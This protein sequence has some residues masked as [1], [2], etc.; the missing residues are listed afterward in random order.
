MVTRELSQLTGTV[1]GYRRLLALA[2]DLVAANEMAVEAADPELESEVTEGLAELV[3]EIARLEVQTLFS[4]ELDDRPAILSVN[5]GA[6]GTDAQDW[7]EMLLRMYLRWAEQ[8][9]FQAAVTEALAGEEAGVKSATIEVR[10]PHAYGW[11]GSEHGVH[12]LVRLSPFDSAHR[13]HT[14]FASVD[15]VP[16]LEEE[17]IEIEIPDEELRI[18]T[19]RAGGP[20]GQYVN[21][22]DSAVRITHLP[23]GLVTT[24]QSERSQLSNKIVAMKH[25]K[26]KL[27]ERRRQERE[28]EMAQLRGEQ[29]KIDF[30]S[31]IRSYVLHPYQMVKDHRTGA[32]TSSV[33]RVLDGD[34]TDLM[35]SWLQWRA[36]GDE[37]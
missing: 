19:F 6:G 34:L 1:D 31:Q 11:L 21:T 18:D 3:R 32:E 30:G 14:A 36:R 13:R 26:V 33:D 20:G 24:C 35:T 37:G 8:N 25:M 17:S 2:D 23:T 9:G 22:T 29:R 4:G 27:L 15:V 10:G 16:E 7:T 5:A 28:A 12:R